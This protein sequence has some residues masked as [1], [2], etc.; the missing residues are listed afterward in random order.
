MGIKSKGYLLL[1]SLKTF[2]VPR[3]YK[4]NMKERDIIGKAVF[5]F[6]T[7]SYFDAQADVQWHNHG[8][9]RPQLLGLR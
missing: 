1:D 8:S 6:E 3:L 5:F 4:A 7:V 9:L 2:P